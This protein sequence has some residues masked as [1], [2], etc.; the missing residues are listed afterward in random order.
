MIPAILRAHLEGPDHLA[1]IGPR[2]AKWEHIHQ[3][4]HLA[5]RIHRG[6]T[7]H[8]RIQLP[9]HQLVATDNELTQEVQK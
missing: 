8:E 6:P 4:L 9:D 3:R 2:P 5:W 1:V 7:Q